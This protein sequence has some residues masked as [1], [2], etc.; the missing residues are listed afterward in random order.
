MGMLLGTKTTIFIIHNSPNGA[1][2]V[3]PMDNHQ[4]RYLVSEILERANLVVI[5]Q[6]WRKGFQNK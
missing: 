3:I 6:K 5:V 2:L 1:K 4:L